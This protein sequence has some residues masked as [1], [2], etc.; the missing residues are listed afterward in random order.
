MLIMPLTIFPD[1]CDLGIAALADLKKVNKLTT[2]S[3]ADD[4]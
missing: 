4:P 3:P 1:V 2:L